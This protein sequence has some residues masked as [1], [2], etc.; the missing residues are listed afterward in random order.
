MSSEQAAMPFLKP[1]P[2]NFDFVAPLK[3]SQVLVMARL[4]REMRGVSQ[5]KG[6]VVKLCRR[7]ADRLQ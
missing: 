1:R 5:V 3:L 7:V 2:L 4:L 6:V